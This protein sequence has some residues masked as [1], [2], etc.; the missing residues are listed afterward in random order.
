MTTTNITIENVDRY[1]EIMHKLGLETL[2]GIV[3]NESEDLYDVQD[4]FDDFGYGK[5]ADIDIERDYTGVELV[6]L[7]IQAEDAEAAY[8][9]ARAQTDKELGVLLL[10]SYADFGR[11]ILVQNITR[12]EAI[13]AIDKFFTTPTRNTL[14]NSALSVFDL[15]EVV[16]EV[17]T[18]SLIFDASIG[19]YG[20]SFDAFISIVDTIEQT[21]ANGGIV[22]SF[23]DGIESLPNYSSIPKL[24]GLRALFVPEYF[25]E[26]NGAVDGTVLIS[27]TIQYNKNWAAQGITQVH[28]E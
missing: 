23:A 26:G 14:K 11:L 20:S 8:V 28:P 10:P 13:E 7:F 12:G 22:S 21:V 19:E 27:T 5:Y 1:I 6:E 9:A 4:I 24:R 16:S 25:L 18:D 3:E 2:Q 17:P 15:G